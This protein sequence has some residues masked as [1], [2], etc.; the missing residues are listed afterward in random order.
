MK[1]IIR[2]YDSMNQE[3][4]GKDFESL[5]NGLLKKLAARGYSA[6]TVTGYRYLCN[7]I[8]AQLKSLGYEAYTQGGGE[9]VLE[10]YLETHGK[11]QY[12]ENLRTVVKRLDDELD[13]IWNDIHSSKGRTFDLTED[14]SIRVNEYCKQCRNKGLADG[15]VRIKAYSTSWFCSILIDLGCEHITDISAELVSRSCIRITDHNLWG[16]IRGF[17]RYLS[18]EGITAA[19]YSTIVPH[20]SRPY[21]IPAVYSIDEIKKIEAVIDRTTL[22]GKR[23]YAMILLASRLG[24]RSGDI[25]LLR[26]KDVDFNTDEVNIIQQK[27]GKNL[28]LPLIPEVKTALQEYLDARAVF[29]EEHI[30]LNVYAPYHPVTTSTMRSAIRK[31]MTLA[32]IDIGAR[33]HGPHSLRSSLASAMVNDSI[34]YETVRKVLGHSSNNAIKHYA[35][36]DIEKLR[37]YSIPPA[38]PSGAFLR[39]L[40]GEV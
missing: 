10:N 31:Y 29:E 27:T 25:V 9:C 8:I 3:K 16:E 7:S 20:F 35:R 23:D 14:F 22:L 37:L 28:H 26:C 4:A 34:S 39:Y 24:M 12:Y 13:D 6:V 19:D 2:R 21:V 33:K 11:N 17:L 1:N 40:N 15:T 32:A 5:K 30:F 36:I 38:E 18:D